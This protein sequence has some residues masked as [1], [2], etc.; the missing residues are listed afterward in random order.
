MTND[1]M[2]D[3]KDSALVTKMLELI[4]AQ[5]PF[6]LKELSE[7]V[8]IPY[9]T[10]ERRIHKMKHAGLITN[11]RVGRRWLWS[12]ESIEQP[13]FNADS[14]R[15]FMVISGENKPA[16][17]SP[18]LYVVP[19]EEVPHEAPHFEVEDSDS[20]S[21]ETP[22]ET[23][24]ETPQLPN[25]KNNSTLT[26]TEQQKYN[27]MIVPLSND[28]EN[29]CSREKEKLMPV[30]RGPKSPLLESIQKALDTSQKP[31]KKPNR[32][33]TTPQAR[34]RERMEEKDETEYNV[35]DMRFV[36]EDLW[37]EKSWR[38][39]PSRWTMKDKK[40]VRN[41]LDEQ[42]GKNTVRYFQY[43]VQ[44]W[45]EIQQRYRI[46]GAP[47]MSVIWGFRNSLLHEALNNIK[48]P[49]SPT[50]EYEENDAA[51]DGSFF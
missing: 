34:L 14:R 20:T 18:I 27:S 15:A 5:V 50:L 25:N 44:G 19:D 43:V 9:K 45:E 17:K 29:R 28:V 40:L 23:P 46:Q 49:S 16:E 36:Y 22:K 32:V 13:I 51:K 30:I 7:E 2:F 33:K 41:L 37:A 38:T 42:G 21:Q 12:L 31:R 26:I 35:T 6:T 4:K 1:R 10:V 11:R 47:S 24:Q 8:C 48:K 39:Y 3:L